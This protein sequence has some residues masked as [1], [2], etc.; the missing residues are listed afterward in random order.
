MSRD[1]R[2]TPKDI[3]VSKAEDEGRYSCTSKRESSSGKFPKKSPLVIDLDIS[4][5]KGI[6][7][8]ADVDSPGRN[9]DLGYH[10][11]GGGGETNRSFRISEKISV[12]LG[13][14]VEGEDDTRVGRSVRSKGDGLGKAGGTRFV[15]LGRVCHPLFETQEE[16]QPGS[17]QVLG[18]DRGSG[19]NLDSS[20]ELG[21]PLGWVPGLGLDFRVALCPVPPIG[22]FLTGRAFLS[23]AAPYTALQ[24]Q[25]RRG[26]PY[27]LGKKTSSMRLQS[28]K[29]TAII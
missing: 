26:M 17:G 24:T 13:F 29:T 12:G 22:L 2:C 21:R 14:E 16:K 20:K 19:P 7:Y 11:Q 28:R 5:V 8:F 25:D 6:F 27:T 3:E 9:T 4:C 23:L 1:E 18:S 15:S 10:V